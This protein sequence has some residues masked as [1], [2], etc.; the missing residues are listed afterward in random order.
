M[1][2]RKMKEIDDDVPPVG[3]IDNG[4]NDVVDDQ[5]YKGWH[6]FEGGTDW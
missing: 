6:T 2:A 4:L 3:F 1:F 5:E